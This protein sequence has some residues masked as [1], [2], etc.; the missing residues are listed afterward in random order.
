[1]VADDDPA[2]CSRA[3][4]WTALPVMNI[5]KSATSARSP[6]DQS[7]HDS[8]PGNQ[9]PGHKSQGNISQGHIPPGNAPPASSKAGAVC[10]A[11]QMKHTDFIR[12]SESLLIVSRYQLVYS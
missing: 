2:G 12:S 4:V 11:A 3:N 8:S 6:H 7:P 5:V 9:S 10:A 1:M